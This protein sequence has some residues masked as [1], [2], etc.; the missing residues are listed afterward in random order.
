M[1]STRAPGVLAITITGVLWGTTGTAA[2]F[3]PT[4]GPLAIGAAALGIGGLLQALIA[5]K[6]LRRARS[7]LRRRAGIIALG[8]LAVAI[9][10]LAFY[11]SMHLAGVAVGS[12]VSLASAP[13]ASGVLD[14]FVNGRALSR[15]WMLAAGLGMVGGL[16]LCLAGPEAHGP[17]ISAALAA[18]SGSAA[19]APSAS[20]TTALGIGL[21]LLAG[22]T[23]AT[24][25]WVVH[26]L[27]GDGIR[28][29]AAMG[30]VF[31]GGGLLLL[32][33][34]LVTGAPLVASGTAFGV[35]AYMAL[36]PM[37]LGY[38]LFGFGLTRVP[39]S[40]A[41]TITLVEPAVAAVLAVVVV[42]EVLSALGWVGLGLIGLVLLVL[43][44]APTT[45][46]E[47]TRPRCAVRPRYSVE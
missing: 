30:A 10:P 39:A 19:E 31:G 26:R 5:L 36:V 34:L 7:H 11:S 46:E 37:F 45:V 27:M 6:S 24:Y 13:L 18:T 9:Y 38:L 3:A 25:S 29:S 43:A 44:L 12:V 32:P 42:G 16:L 8:A 21:G 1:N 4:A 41:T 22:L 20:L 35:A 33:V 47:R 2:T 14:R 15:W 28:R 40:T 17:G 23:Y